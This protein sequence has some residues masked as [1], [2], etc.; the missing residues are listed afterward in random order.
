MLA[1][2]VLLVAGVGGAFSNDD[3]VDSDDVGSAAPSCQVVTYDLSGTASQVSITM[4]NAS[5]NTEQ[6]QR[7]LPTSIGLGCVP[8]SQ[9]CHLGAE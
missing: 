7:A 1:D 3:D 6:T 5:G 8:A 9:F 2:A 4:E